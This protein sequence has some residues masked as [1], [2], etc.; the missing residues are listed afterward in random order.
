[1][2]LDSFE[3]RVRNGVHGSLLGIRVEGVCRRTALE[4]ALRPQR[5]SD[6]TADNCDRRGSRGGQPDLTTSSRCKD[7][8]PAFARVE[9]NGQTM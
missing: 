6:R 3:Q 4:K 7:G 9:R 8:V 2:E 5:L 1:M